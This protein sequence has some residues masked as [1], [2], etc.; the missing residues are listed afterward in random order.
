MTAETKYNVINNLIKKGHQWIGSLSGE[1]IAAFVVAGNGMTPEKL[2][3]F[4]RA[5]INADKC[6]REFRVIDALPRNAAGK[7]EKKKL[8]AIFTGESAG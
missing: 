2:A 8:V 3:I 4:A 1:E 6:P 5:S 7:V